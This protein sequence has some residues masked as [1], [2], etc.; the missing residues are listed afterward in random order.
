M[1]SPDSR[2]NTPAGKVLSQL[3]HGPKSVEELARALRITGNAVRNQLRKLQS[4]SLVARAGTR[5][6]ASKPSALY[7]ITLEGQIRFSTLYLPVLTQFLRV[8]EERC[9]TAQLES[10]MSDTGRALAGRYSKPSG[11]L[12]TRIQ[13][14][15]RLVNSLG[16]ASE[17]LSRGGELQLRSVVCPLAALTIEEP[18][19][20]NLLGSLL[21]EYVDA[22][23]TSCCDRSE[24]PKCCFRVKS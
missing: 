9:S 7:G 3:R 6:G 2:V 11:A 23:L 10:F 13:A 15:A 16:G 18:A 19:A 12:R 22:S 8:A 4:E 17:V 24:A 5:A 21:G 1:H 14:A 20:C